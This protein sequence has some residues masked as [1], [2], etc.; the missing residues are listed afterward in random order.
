[1]KKLLII[2]LALSLLLLAGCKVNVNVP[3]G[4]PIGTQAPTDNQNPTDDVTEPANGDSTEVGGDKEEFETPI[5]VDDDY[6]AG[7]PSDPTTPSATDP[8][9]TN[10]ANPTEPVEPTE[11][12]EPTEPAGST[13]PPATSV[14]DP[15]TGA[16][17]LPMIPG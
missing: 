1:M 15:N 8:S 7:N 11:P 2:C 9:V 6:V 10:P 3:A 5:D 14:T 12:T 17:Q 4:D 16:I 13:E